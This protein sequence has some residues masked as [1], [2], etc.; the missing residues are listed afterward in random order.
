MLLARQRGQRVARVGS[1]AS[2]VLAT[3]ERDQRLDAL[4]LVD[5]PQAVDR[6]REERTRR[7]GEQPR[8]VFE[9]ARVAARDAGAE[10]DRPQALVLGGVLDDRPQALARRELGERREEIDVAHAAVDRLLRPRPA[11]EAE[12]ERALGRRAGEGVEHPR[13]PADQ[14]AEHRRA[15][16]RVGA[17]VPELD[18]RLV[19]LLLDPL[20]L[21]VEGVHLLRCLGRLGLEFLDLGQDQL[22]RGLGLGALLLDRGRAA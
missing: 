22:E 17:E 4:D 16:D 19:A 3:E 15:L 6:T 10:R 18:G 2:E 21:L 7:A 8:A 1:Q 12:R 20:D 13:E 11:L 14:R 9:D 5:A